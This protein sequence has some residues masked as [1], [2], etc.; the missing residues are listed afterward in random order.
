M[1][2]A[3]QDH[4]LQTVTKSGAP[5]R[6]R[7]TTVEAARATYRRIYD[8]MAQEAFRRDRIK[9]QI[10]GHPPW[11]QE[12][13]EELGL[14]YVTNVNY[15]ELRAALDDRA[16]RRFSSYYDVPFL[17]RVQQ[18]FR[19]D[20][21]KPE[22]P[23]PS[24]IAEEFTRLL[25]ED[26]SGFH[27][28]LD[29]VGRES[30]AYGYGVALFP[31]EW[32]WRPKAFHTSM[33]FPDP[34]S[35]LDPDE[36][37]L[38]CLHD[39][40]SAGDLFRFIDNPDVATSAG[41]NVLAVRKLLIRLFVAR[42]SQDDG[43]GDQQGT[44]WE[45]VEQHYRNNDFL[46]QSREFD[47]V[48]VVHLLYTQVA[49]R[50]VG[51]KIFPRATQDADEF[52]FSDVGE[53]ARMSNA[54]WLLPYNY[55]DGY[56]RSCRGIASYL[57][58]HC[59]SSN[60]FLGQAMDA[61][62]TA[63]S[64]LVQPKSAVAR[65]RLNVVRM[66]ILTLIDKDLDLQ[67]QNFQPKIGDI[68]TL[69]RV[70][71]D[72]VQ[73]NTRETK[74]Y[75]EDPSA[76]QQPVSAAEINAKVSRSAR[77]ENQQTVFYSKHLQTLYREIFRRLVNP[78]V[79][80]SE[81][82]TPGKEL[83]LVFVR[84]CVERGVPLELLLN[85][86][87]WRIMAVK[88]VGG[89]SPQARQQ[90]LTNLMQP[91]VYGGLDERGRREVLREYVAAQTSYE[92][93]D[94]FAPLQNRDEIASNEHSVAALETAAF[95]SGT[96]VPAGSDQV[97]T[98][99]FKSHAQPLVEMVKAIQEQG[100]GAV[101]VQRGMMY[102]S[103]ALPNMQGH[104]QY[105]QLDPTRKN[106]VQEG[107]QILR[108]GTQ[109]Y[110][111]FRKKLMKDRQDAAQREADR[112]A[113]VKDAEA[114]ALT[115]EQQVELAKAEMNTRV[116]AMKVQSLNEMRLRKTSEQ[117]SIDAARAQHEMRLREERQ[118]AELALEEQKVQA[119]ISRKARAPAKSGSQ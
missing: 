23:Y 95:A 43:H 7:I 111:L 73:N 33:F 64:L 90:A 12:K 54:L 113:Q 86:D 16:A 49:D 44:S 83:A 76:N 53:F 68:L 37:P 32:D 17:V 82:D 78:D 69:R 45:S 94:R 38:F 25:K 6:D 15:L 101:D 74:D 107:V 31:N 26:W 11:D 57:E 115:A 112:D 10:D 75:A 28:L 88:P 9:G 4:E 41:W 50:K 55:G 114:R 40:F 47:Q 77:G 66:G 60:R 104:L 1:T 14:G 110:D 35:K 67:Q 108:Q 98:I 24:I 116:A 61:G 30:D 65:D 72:I 119:D 105:L 92:E 99:H 106:F 18:N 71:S 56:L 58:Q 22:Q 34:N 100:I 21:S 2:D 103:A 91:A 52:L 3:K 48:K 93:L 97:H 51:H 80:L 42:E 117:L 62:K 118:A 96:S 70:S 87:N 46:F 102:L 20:Q 19:Y 8:S 59:D 39:E 27:P 36:I 63:A 5:A 81:A 109:L 13:L 89:G 79:I 84:R 29:L 85:Q